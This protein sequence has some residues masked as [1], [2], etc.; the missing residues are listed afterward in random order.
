M[1]GVLLIGHA[2]VSWREWLKENQ[3]RRD[4]IVLDPADASLTIPARLSLLKGDKAIA[5]RFYGSIEPLR[6]PHVMV[7]ALQQLLQ[8][9]GEDCLIQMPAYR[10]SP[11]A[12]QLLLV[13]AQL[14]RPDEIIVAEGTNL[15][16][17]AL[18]VGPEIVTLEPAFPAMVL[19]AQRKAHWLKLLETCRPH[20]IQLSELTIEGTRLG[21]GLRLGAAALD[22]LRLPGV[23]WAEIAGS[24]LFIVADD[25][26]EEAAVA[27]ALDHLHASRA[28]FAAPESYDGLLC[29]FAKASGEDFGYGMIERIDFDEGVAHIQNTAETPAPVR[30]LR[31]GSLR[32]NAAGTELGEARPWQV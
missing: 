20:E 13:L 9:A 11:L 14:A 1:R 5:S 12:H 10:S 4:L 6:S 2:G 3:D 28:H 7:A 26:P 24:S 25:E 17:N 22:K 8:V 21:S 32:I 29:S 16:S 23:K 18:P 27:R 30:I 31:V 19:A 15:P